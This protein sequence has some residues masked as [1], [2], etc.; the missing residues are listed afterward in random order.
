MFIHHIPGYQRAKRAFQNLVSKEVS[1]PKKTVN[2]DAIYSSKLCKFLKTKDEVESCTF[3][4]YDNGFVSHRLACKDWDL[5]H[6]IPHINDGNFL[7]MGS[8]DSYILRNVVLKGIKGKKYGIDLRQPEAKVNGVTYVIGDIVNTNLPDGHFKNITCLSV[9]E[10]EVD[11]SLLAKEASRLLA[12]EGKLF[13][14]FDYCDP[15]LVTDIRLYGLQWQPLDKEASDVFIEACKKNNLYLVQDVDW[16]VEDMVIQA[17]YY[18]P[19][20]SVT[21]TFGLFVFQKRN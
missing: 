20:P 1:S 7:D 9:I 18:A 5:A 8:S 17:N 16:T 13:V 21:Y 4:L 14:T 10:H 6:I 11:F 12:E 3:F 19:H 15:K 2:R